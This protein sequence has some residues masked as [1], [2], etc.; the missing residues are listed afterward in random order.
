M[1]VLDWWKIRLRRGAIR[2]AVR[3]PMPQGFTYGD[4]RNNNY[5][6]H[7]VD[8]DQEF[9]FTPQVVLLEGLAGWCSVDRQPA[10]DA[11]LPNAQIAKLPFKITHHYK[12]FSI[13]T[14]SPA[15]FIAQRLVSYPFFA[16]GK[17]RIAQFLFNRRRLA[18][19]DRIAV[20]RYIFDQ[21]VENSGYRTSNTDL[22][23]RIY[24]MRFWGR[25]DHDFHLS[26][27][28]LVLDSLKESGDL[29]KVDHSYVLSPKAVATLDAHE[30]QQERHRD[31]IGIQRRIALITFVLA[32]LAA[33]QVY[34]TVWQ[35]LHPDPTV[36]EP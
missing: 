18:R 2:I 6:I 7:L 26:Y 11:S 16:A 17:Q 14:A 27:Y 1:G 36:R 33:A 23:S 25:D 24:G 3:R 9:I 19:Q 30:T 34:T 21:T 5:E 4:R 15:L 22:P 8:R 29:E 20:L 10:Y 31:N 35:E 12:G 28:Q 32:I 13:T